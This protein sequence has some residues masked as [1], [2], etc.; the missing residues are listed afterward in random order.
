VIKQGTGRVFAAFAFVW[1]LVASPLAAAPDPLPSWND[2]ASKRAIVAVVAQV[3]KAGTPDFVPVPQ[4]I[5]TFDNDGTLWVEQPIY[6]Q[7][8]FAFDRVKLLSAGHPLVAC[9]VNVVN[10]STA[11]C[12][13]CSRWV[14]CQSSKANSFFTKKPSRKSPR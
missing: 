12:R 10:T 3:T 14:S 9:S 5:A 1:L 4:R 6:T 7:F 2:G 13:S 8:A 11:V